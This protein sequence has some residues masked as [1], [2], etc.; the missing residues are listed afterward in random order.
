MGYD[1]DSGEIRVLQV[2]NISPT[3]TKEQIHQLFSYIGRIEECQ[4]FPSNPN[5]QASQKLA[6][7]KY[8]KKNSIETGQHLTNIVFIDRALICVPAPSNQ[9]PDEETALQSGGAGAGQRQLPPHVINQLQDVGD[10]QKMLLTIDPTLS[11][12]GLPPYP[13]LPAE[14][15]S[16]KV[17][18]IR[19]T[20]YVGNLPKDVDGDELME[21][22][23]TNIGEVMYLRMTAGND[24][25]P[26]AYA[27]IE[28][29]NQ[30]TVPL[31]LQNNGIEFKGRPLRITHSRVA[32]I[33]PQRKTADQALEEV[34]EAIK[35]DQAS[36]IDN[37]RSGSVGRGYSPYTGGSPR[38]RQS[39]S[40]RSSRRRSSTRSR[41][42][43]PPPRRRNRSRTR[44]PSPKRR[45]RSRSRDRD[46][47]RRSRTPDRR[48]RS[49]DRDREERRRRSRSRK[50]SKSRDRDRD[51]RRDRSKSRER[52]RKRD[53]DRDEKKDRRDKDKE[54]DRKRSRSKSREKKEEKKSRSDRE[55]DKE[56][57]KER[58]SSPSE[59]DRDRN[60]EKERRSEKEVKKEKDRDREKTKDEKSDKKRKY[61]SDEEEEDEFKL[62]ERLLEKTQKSKSNGAGDK[63]KRQAEEIETNNGVEEM[64]TSD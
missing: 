17:E 31:A 45:R 42:P 40:P 39:P 7:I 26:C 62:R 14:T 46:S 32:I 12:L 11:S 55:R 58:K 25:L 50:R 21:F 34:E 64:D 3:A 2:S 29:T 43:S 15:E 18:E 20:V 28:F 49:R 51:R 54:R 41:S 60:K 63:I 56:A 8:D 59:R 47:R 22:F 33:K 10:G 13:G 35:R 9:I 30:S 23:N 36:G 61:E 6:Y 19:R 24:N 52:D 27:Y 4:V 38:R 53:K 5:A 48:S 16:S 1:D 57:K 37:K 44:S